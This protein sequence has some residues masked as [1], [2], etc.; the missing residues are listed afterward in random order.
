MLYLVFLLI[1][2]FGKLLKFQTITS[3]PLFHACS[4]FLVLYEYILYDEST[5][6]MLRG[7]WFHCQNFMEKQNSL[8]KSTQ[9]TIVVRIKMNYRKREK[10]HKASCIFVS[11]TYA[12]FSAARR[13]FKKEKFSQLPL[14]LLLVQPGRSVSGRSPPCWDLQQ[15]RW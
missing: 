7:C 14:D 5:Q 11:A 10:M 8:Y 15:Q 3:L 12:P 2:A 6:L 1:K 9:Q 4:F 13:N